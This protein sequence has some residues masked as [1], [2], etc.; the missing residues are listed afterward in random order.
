M[1][2][3]HKI[4]MENNN[5]NNHQ[6]QTRQTAVTISQN[7]DQSVVSALDFFFL[8]ISK[9]YLFVIT[10]CL[11]LGIAI[12]Y[13]MS[14]HPQY[15]AS[16][17]LIIKQDRRAGTSGLEMESSMFS[18]MGTLFAQ[19]SNVFN[20]I[21]AFESPSL[22]E[23][24][25][26]KLDLR[27]N[28][29][30]DHYLY[31]R[32]LYGQSLPVSIK[33]IDFPEG[34]SCGMV[35]G[36]KDANHVELSQMYTNT[37][38]GR[39]ECAEPI[40]VCLNDTTETPVGKLMAVPNL[41][42]YDSATPFIPI[43]LTYT[44]LSSATH[45]YSGRL[46]VSL[47]NKEATA[48]TLEITDKTAA[49]ARDIISTLIDVYNEK[50]ISDR[51]Q[52]SVST[53][54]FISDRLMVIEREL[55][56]VDRSL[57]TYKS[58]NQLLDPAMTGSMYVTQVNKI[59]NEIMDLNN[60]LSMAKYVKDYMQSSANDN[61]LLPAN[62]GI[63][64]AN[65]EGLITEFNTKQLQRNK[66]AAN[67]S[68]ASPV[69]VQMDAALNALH[70]SIIASID[71][72][73]TIL[74]NQ[75][76]SQQRNAS[77]S[78]AKIAV[79]PMQAEH[80]T[81]I[82]RQQKVKESLYL[83][84][85][86]K[87]EENELSQAFTAYNTRIIMNPVAK[88]TPVA[89]NR[90]R[91]LMIA[92]LIGLAIPVGLIYLMEVTNIKVRSRR[93][94][95]KLSA[96][97]AGEIPLGYRRKK[98]SHFKPSQDKN[99]IVVKAKSRDVMNEAFRVVRSNLEF[100]CRDVPQDKGI[101]LATTSF[102]VGSGKTFVSANLSSAMALRG[103]KVIAVDLDLR[104]ATL[105][106]YVGKPKEGVR[107]YL[108]GKVDDISS[109]LIKGTIT[110]GLDILPV[111]AIPPNPSELLYSDRLG[112]LI[113]KLR[114]EYDFIV[115][116]CPPVEIVAD[117]SI[118]NKFVDKTLFVIRAELLDRDMLPEVE[119][120]YVEGKFANMVLLLNGTEGASGYG[121]RKYGYGRYGYGYGYGRSYGYGYI[122]RY[123][124]GHH[125]GYG[126]GST[127]SA[128]GYGDPSDEDVDS[129][130]TKNSNKA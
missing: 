19:Q 62:S 30:V 130:N 52:I 35:I 115:I 11:A 55:G 33:L 4:E 114:S 122:H 103:R 99:E 2:I 56:G 57:S 29:T 74:T 5:N 34:R 76:S 66:L 50:W 102:N 126:Y 58:R 14:T 82:E 42:Y 7:H 127:K 118:I 96:P 40:V 25:V 93:D 120:L 119:R 15:S 49:R 54:R 1:E 38:E 90:N 36:F 61:K 72:Y 37:S 60:R 20:E 3:G 108:S 97:F 64:N 28:Y 31:K 9:W 84:L 26:K 110:E 27:A 88:N 107:D 85:L 53:S 59:Q 48:I 47:T 16:S 83:Y 112:T 70:S 92:L 87:R 8:C 113:E 105:S 117:P 81:D 46:G 73:I 128:Y 98:F 100:I 41:A 86:Q 125:Y 18:S 13:I 129:N 6:V 77:I 24:V 95:D 67:S 43:T 121:Y 51:N 124:Y 21:I 65:I 94:L 23:S 39:L 89:P 123:G 106:H 78:S 79:N 116:D 63:E 111:G 80:L 91:V 12:F 44:T 22:M 32:T 10:V 104:K 69:V 71:N 45:A 17:C 68:V 101:V 109:L 75:I